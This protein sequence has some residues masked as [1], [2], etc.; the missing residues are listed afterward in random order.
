M[1]NLIA[2]CAHNGVIGNN[3]I[4]PC[5]I[6]GE[7]SRFKELTLGNVVVMGRRSYEE[8]GKPLPN[9]I[10]IVVSKTRRFDAENCVTV[11]SL[12]EALKI[13]GNKDV[14]I[15]GGSMLYQE[16]LPLVDKMYITEIDLAVEGDTFFPNFN[17]ADFLKEAEQRI[18][19]KIPYTYITY[20]RK[21]KSELE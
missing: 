5:K 4:I 12:K 15:S 17:E 10:T 16:A 9:R 1:I 8:I 18:E 6:K 21:V 13:A 2:A 20:I 11:S 3:G 7:Q 19:G 14:Y